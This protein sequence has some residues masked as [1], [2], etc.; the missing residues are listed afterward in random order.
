[1]AGASKAIRLPKPVAY[2]KLLAAHTNAC[3]LVPKLVEVNILINSF[4]ENILCITETWLNYEVTDAE[5]ALENYN[6]F[7]GD[8]QS[9]RWGGCVALYVKSALLPHCFS[10]DLNTDSFFAE[11]VACQIPHP[12]QL[13]TVLRVYKSPTSPEAYDEQIIRA[14]C[15]V[16]NQPG[17]CLILGDFNAPH[18][19]WQTSTCSASLRLLEV[20]EEEFLFQAITSPTR[21]SEDN[22]PSLLDLAFTKYPDDVSSV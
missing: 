1:M 12:S 16:A 19:N 2:K 7:R 11:V 4:S 9:G 10:L 5:V 8:R 3:S 14:I 6:I 22:K 17:I 20:A 15:L 13:L 18:I 21:F